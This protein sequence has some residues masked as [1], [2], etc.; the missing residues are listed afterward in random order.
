MRE[1]SATAL[2]K[3][4]TNNKLPPTPDSEAQTM[5]TL[6]QLAYS[7]SRTDRNTLLTY[8]K[9]LQGK[10]RS[11]YTKTV[12]RAYDFLHFVID[13]RVSRH[14]NNLFTDTQHIIDV[15]Q[16]LWGLI[17][18]LVKFMWHQLLFIASD[19]DLPGNESEDA[20][21]FTSL[22]RAI[23]EGASTSR[24]SVPVM[25]AL[26]E[27]SDE[28]YNDYLADISPLI[29]TP[30]EDL[31]APFADY[32]K[33]TIS[34]FSEIAAASQK[35][36]PHRWSQADRACLDRANHKLQTLLVQQRAYQADTAPAAAGPLPL[37]SPMCAAKLIDDWMAVKDIIFI[38]SPCILPL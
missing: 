9:T 32:C 22:A 28:A 12:N 2:L 7:T 29:G 17:S 27:A 34:R 30:H 3:L 19:S 25:D 36:E 33:A 37:L 35:D 23:Q 1:N 8:A 11:S 38:V 14:F 10:H 15:Q 21:F 16:S 5:S 6:F 20:T 4:V 18:P 31:A 24:V 26:V 13:L